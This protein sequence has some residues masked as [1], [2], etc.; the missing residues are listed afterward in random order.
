MVYNL[1]KHVS[2]LSV[3]DVLVVCFTGQRTMS[4]HTGSQSFKSANASALSI[5]GH[6]CPINVGALLSDFHVY[7]TIVLITPTPVG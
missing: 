6:I 3:C 1:D 5:A 2:P 4:L 7:V